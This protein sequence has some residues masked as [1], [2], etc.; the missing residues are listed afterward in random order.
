MP[1]VDQVFEQ[2]GGFAGHCG[3][4]TVHEEDEVGAG[5]LLCELRWDGAVDL[6]RPSLLVTEALA[7]EQHPG[8][9]R[10]RH[11]GGRGEPATHAQALDERGDERAEELAVVLIEGAQSSEELSPVARVGY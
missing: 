1:A 9:H 10:G 2:D 6:G 3:H 5:E 4:G 8:W 7:V 11:E